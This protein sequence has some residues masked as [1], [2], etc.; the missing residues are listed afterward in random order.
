MVSETQQWINFGFLIAIMAAFLT[1]IIGNDIRRRWLRILAGTSLSVVLCFGVWWLESFSLT[2]RILAALQSPAAFM[3]VVFMLGVGAFAFRKRKNRIYGQVEII[4]AMLSAM[5]IAFGKNQ[6]H[7]GRLVA[8]LTAAYVVQRGLNNWDEA[9]E[10][11]GDRRGNR[12][13][14]ELARTMT[15]KD[16]GD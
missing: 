6:S 16:T 3:L 2:H 10:K 15:F 7:F 1:L 5:A 13:I 12:S 4:A 9:L 14:C 11:D 8:V